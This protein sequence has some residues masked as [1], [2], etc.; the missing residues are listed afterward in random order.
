MDMFEKDI[1]LAITAEKTCFLS[2]LFL[3][4]D[5]CPRNYFFNGKQ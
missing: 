1:G 2:L 3:N 4:E 5:I